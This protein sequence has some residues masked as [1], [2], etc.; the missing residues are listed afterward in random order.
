MAERTVKKSYGSNV[1]GYFPS[2]I[3][4]E[5]IFYE[6]HIEFDCLRLLDFNPLVE[7]IREQPMTIQYKHK[8]R[9]RKY[10]PDFYVET[11]DGGKYL[12]E[13]KSHKRLGDEELQP[14]F[15]AGVKW[16]MAN[17]VQYFIATEKWLRNG[18]RLDNVEHLTY[19][20]TH[21]VP[22][23]I[24][25]RI[26]SIMINHGKPL[27]LLELAQTLFPNSPPKAKMP[28]YHMLYHHDLYANLNDEILNNQTLIYWPAALSERYKLAKGTIL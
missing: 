10:I 25:S 4:G 15:Q 19:Y 22:V 27:T 7:D 11:S 5:M 6:S 1:I 9:L 20:S 13:C 12:I 3:T 16:G 14:K 8:G 21:I 28:I 17:G 26:F 18:C 2:Q 23:A 24:K